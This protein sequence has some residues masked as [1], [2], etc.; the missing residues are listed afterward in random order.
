MIYGR[1]KIAGDPAFYTYFRLEGFSWR[2]CPKR[3]AWFVPG[4]LINFELDSVPDD[5]LIHCYKLLIDILNSRQTP[6]SVDLLAKSFRKIKEGG[7]T[8]SGCHFPTAL[9]FIE[10]RRR[11]FK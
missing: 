9:S 8:I 10:A 2:L 5:G 4:T 3:E 11:Q 1:A 6:E 7:G